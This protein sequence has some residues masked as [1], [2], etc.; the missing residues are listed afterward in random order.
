MAFTAPPARAIRRMIPRIAHS[1][2]LR[3]V[4]VDLRNMI[5]RFVLAAL[6]YAGGRFLDTAPD[7]LCANLAES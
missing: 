7:Y 4:A 1:Y 2:W 5:D 6:A 3:V